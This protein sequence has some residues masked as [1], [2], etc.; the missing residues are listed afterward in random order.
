MAVALSVIAETSTRNS[1]ELTYQWLRDGEPVVGAV[2]ASL[3]IPALSS[4][5]EGAY[6]VVVMNADGLTT[7][8]NTAQVSIEFFTGKLKV[9]FAPK[10]MKKAKP[11]G[12]TIKARCK[13]RIRNKKERKALL[14]TG[15]I[16]Y[17]LDEE[18]IATLPAKK[19]RKY[20]HRLASDDSGKTL[21]CAV[22][23]ENRARSKSN[24]V[25]LKVK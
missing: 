13:F 18:V 9:K 11:A 10:K 4:A 25:E 21:R 8:S 17:L 23:E 2:A 1:S 7:T 19:G 6:S 5:N 14:L 20:R 12:K 24:S 16:Q 22:V 3:T 15:Q